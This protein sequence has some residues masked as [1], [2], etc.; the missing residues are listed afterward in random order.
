[1]ERLTVKQVATMLGMTEGTIR[2]GLQKGVFPFGAA[3]KT[4]PGKKHYHYVFYPAKV[5]EYAGVK[6]EEVQD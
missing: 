3:F 1:M 5:R 6:D 2:V 4:D